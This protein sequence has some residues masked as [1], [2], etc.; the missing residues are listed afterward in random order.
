L[1]KQLPQANAQV[2]MKE[3]DVMIVAD[4]TTVEVVK[5]VA[6]EKNVADNKIT[7]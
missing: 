6:R 1:V 7:N 2:E 3:V 5:D 4:A